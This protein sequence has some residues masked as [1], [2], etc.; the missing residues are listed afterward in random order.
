[1]RKKLLFLLALLVLCGCSNAQ[2][3]E[4]DA[5]EAENMIRQQYSVV[6]RPTEVAFSG[7]DETISPEID[8]GVNEKGQTYGP[9]RARDNY[10]G[11]YYDW[12]LVAVFQNGVNGFVLYEELSGDYYLDPA[13]GREYV[14]IYASD[15][16]T[17]LGYFYFNE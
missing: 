1:M 13:S 11:G 14:P 3:T 5:S 12:D 4:M 10:E 2:E 17:L 7:G 6:E 9:S 15:G 8:S 16:E